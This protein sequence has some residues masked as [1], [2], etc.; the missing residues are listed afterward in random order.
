MTNEGIPIERR[1]IGLQVFRPYHVGVV[2]V[3]RKAEVLLQSP[4]MIECAGKRVAHLDEGLLGLIEVR[5]A[6]EKACG[7]L[8]V[9][10]R[11]HA[12]QSRD[13]RVGSDLRVKGVVGQ[14]RKTGLRI[15]KPGKRRR[16]P[17]RYPAR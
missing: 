4:V 14:Q 5:I 17:M 2:P 8:T 15:G 7:N 10:I 16:S 6:G 13:I 9:R 12:A 1:I 11:K 3:T